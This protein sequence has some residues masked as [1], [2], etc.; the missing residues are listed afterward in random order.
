LAESVKICEALDEIS[1]FMPPLICSDVPSLDQELYQFKVGVQHSNKPLILSASNVDTIKKII[2][3]AAIISG[4]KDALNER[5]TFTIAIGLMSPLL[6]T[7]D[8]CDISIACAKSGIPVFLYTQA[9]AGTTSPVT[10]SGT[11]AGSHAET[12]AA[13]TLIKLVN[14]DA[15]IIYNNFSQPFDIKTSDLSFGNPE[16]GLLMATVTQLGKYI[17]L[18]SG[19]GMF[20]TDSPLS[21]M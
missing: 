1:W 11:L 20:A 5:P 12:L 13:T 6:I 9:M 7:S 2:D 18:P 4:S 21:D 3:L 14:P 10:L 15:K 8:L 17:N 16:F 19:T